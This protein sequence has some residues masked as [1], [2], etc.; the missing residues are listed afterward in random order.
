MSAWHTETRGRFRWAESVEDDGDLTIR[1]ARAEL[2]SG[3]TVER[4]DTCEP[5]DGP[6]AAVIFVTDRGG[7]EVTVTVEQAAELAAA[8]TEL[9]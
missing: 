9:P 6:D 2:P 1:C 5:G 4:V 7:C 8:L 3:L